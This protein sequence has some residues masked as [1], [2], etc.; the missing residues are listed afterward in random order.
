MALSDRLYYWDT[1]IFLEHLRGEEVLATKR[2]AISRLLSDN[3]KKQNH[4]I[5]SVL[6]HS[7]V[8]P[9]RHWP[10]DPQKEDVYWSYFQGRYF[11][12]IEISRPIISLAREIRDF[13]YRD[14][15]PVTQKYQM[16]GLGDSIHLAT[17]IIYKATEFHTRDKRP[18]GGNIAP[19]KLAGVSP[20]G[21]IAGQW[22]LKIVDPEDPEPELFDQ[23]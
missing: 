16:L 23:P 5:T 11:T 22:E 1:C 6:T 8:L 12:D 3:Q 21:K 4:I 15:D 2:R 13:Y 19:L 9:K 20:G 17:A 7:E 10:E 14:F 18:S